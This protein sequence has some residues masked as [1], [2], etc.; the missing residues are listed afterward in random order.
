[1]VV[2]WFAIYC[3]DKTLNKT[4]LVSLYWQILSLLGMNT[5]YGFTY[6]TTSVVS[7]LD[8]GYHEQSIMG[9]GREPAQQVKAVAI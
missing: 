5:L 3:Y 8:F 4:S 1:M 2:F 9:Q 6:R 7:F